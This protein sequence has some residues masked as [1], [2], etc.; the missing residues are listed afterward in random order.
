MGESGSQLVT[1]DI[2]ESLDDP[3]PEVR[4]QASLS[5]GHT[6]DHEAVE[7]LVER[8]G[9]EDAESRRQAAWALG[10]IGA[11]EAV[12]HLIPLLT[13][14]YPHVRSAAALAL[15]HLGLDEA[16]GPLLAL[17]HSKDDDPLVHGSAATALGLL[18]RA[19]AFE[20]ILEQMQA[21]G[22]QVYRRQLAVAVGDLLGPVHTFYSYIDKESKVRGERVS[23]TIRALVRLVRK[24]VANQG[25]RDDLAAMA[26]Q[27][28][29][30]YL[31][32]DWARCAKCLAN[33]HESLIESGA[34]SDGLC[35]RYFEWL[36][37]CG[38]E[39]CER[40]GFELCV[41]GMFALER[42]VSPP[43]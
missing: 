20:P 17:L 8:L 10:Q 3:S 38:T 16:V 35:C 33:L 29:D 22:H 34:A 1:R 14:P 21:A 6:A 15:G 31:E 25:L 9:H 24:M 27:A 42:I 18:G 32:G 19:E 40:G 23:R 43:L 39:A 13:D 41:L 28:Q 36:A 11:R 30:A 7:P 2:V 37:K 26:H 12:E 4:H 5:L